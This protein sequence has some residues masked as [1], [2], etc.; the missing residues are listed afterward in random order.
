M[1]TAERPSKK[2]SV[3]AIKRQSKGHSFRNFV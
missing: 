2:K 1:G 3:E